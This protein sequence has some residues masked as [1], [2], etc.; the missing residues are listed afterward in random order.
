MSM[1]VLPIVCQTGPPGNRK[2]KAP[3]QPWNGPA[4]LIRSL[5]QL[6]E[7]D[8]EGGHIVARYGANG[9]SST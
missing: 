2:N 1:I 5:F 4:P 7:C 6:T 8:L 3:L 9:E